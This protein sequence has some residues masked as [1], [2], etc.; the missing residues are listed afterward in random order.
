M[1]SNVP[2][3]P[4]ARA[5]RIAW[6]VLISL[7]GLKLATLQSIP[8]SGDEAYHWEWSRRLDWAYYDHPGMVAW[9]LRFFTSVL[10]VN[11]FAAR[12]PA[13]ICMAGSLAIMWR[14]ASMSFRSERVGLWVLAALGLTPFWQGMS[15]LITTDPPYVF[16]SS[17]VILAGWFA[18]VRGNQW[19]WLGFGLACGLAMDS[20][21]LAGLHWPAIALA[22]WIVP[23]GRKWFRRW[24]PYAALSITLAVFSPVLLWNY[25][26]EWAT[27]RFHSVVR[28]DSAAFG[29]YL[30]RFLMGQPLV[31]G[32]ILWPACL[33]AVLRGR[34]WRNLPETRFLAAM[35]S[36]LVL[37]A[38]L[39]VRSEVGLHW[40]SVQQSSLLAVGVGIAISTGWASKAIKFGTY[41][42]LGFAIALNVLLA[43]PTLMLNAEVR[44]SRA[45]STSALDSLFGWRK[46]GDKLTEVR[47]A[48]K[49]PPIYLNNNYAYAAVA[50]FYTPGNPMVWQ[51]GDPSPYGRAYQ[52][53]MRG[54]DWIGKDAIYFRDRPLK[55]S[56]RSI[57]ATAFERIEEEPPLDVYV[58]GRKVRTW[59]LFRC[60]GFKLHPWQ[61]YIDNP[62]L[63]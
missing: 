9:I 57:L 45:K 20:K 47:S 41:L 32:L 33:A 1:N 48:M 11:T 14:I 49:R 52:F 10:G 60:Y 22:A 63:R 61:R 55:D 12:L 44:I 34:T 54:E 46:L 35:A 53:W 58:S 42:N 17:L 30:V 62:M 15:M 36:P 24:E 8:L 26:H 27:F 59:Y 25:N 6:I 28:Q 29:T 18:L 50:S 23:D 4:E 56:T 51:F 31:Y 43:M 38:L 3:E 37:M 19:A 7:I 5:K 40:S 21:F 2:A 16:F 13:L 39:S